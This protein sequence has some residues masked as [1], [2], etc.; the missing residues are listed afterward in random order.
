MNELVVADLVHA[1]QWCRKKPRMEFVYVGI[2][3]CFE[4]RENR[5]RDW[6]KGLPTSHALGW[7]AVGLLAIVIVLVFVRQLV[8]LEG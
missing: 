4:T 2:G 1:L 3:P 5:M 6:L 7:A 8:G